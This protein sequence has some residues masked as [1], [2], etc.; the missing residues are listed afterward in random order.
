M[1]NKLKF[2]WIFCFIIFFLVLLIYGNHLLKER[3]KKLENEKTEAVDL[4]MMAEEI[5]NDGMQVQI[6]SIQIAKEISE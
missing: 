3:I 2:R 5:Q 4:W 6:W 1:G